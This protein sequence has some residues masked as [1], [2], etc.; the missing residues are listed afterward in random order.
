VLADTGPAA[1]A[2]ALEEVYRAVEAGDGD[3]QAEGAA[4]G[5]GAD[6]VLF[7]ERNA[8]ACAGAGEGA[9]E[10]CDAAADYCDFHGVG[11]A[12]IWWVG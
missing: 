2:F 11:I 9:D 4:G 10:A 5:A 6:C 1:D 8:M 3:K 7:V 12:G